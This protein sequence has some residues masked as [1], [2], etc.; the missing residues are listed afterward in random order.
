MSLVSRNDK[1]IGE[2]KYVSLKWL[3][4]DW[5]HFYCFVTWPVKVG[6]IKQT[7]CKRDPL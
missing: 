2:K 1:N 4:P 3:F 7:I 5:I 6:W